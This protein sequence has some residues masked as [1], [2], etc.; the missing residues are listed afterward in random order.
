MSL[1]I[2][3]PHRAEHLGSLKRPQYLLA[4]R[5]E[6]DGKKCSQEDLRVAEDQAIKEIVQMQRDVGMKT[7]TDGEFRRCK[8]FLSKLA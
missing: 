5:D 4:K 3:P 6:F 8:I 1:K 2:N 7:I